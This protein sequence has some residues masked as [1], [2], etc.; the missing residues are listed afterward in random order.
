M[1]KGLDEPDP[2]RNRLDFAGGYNGRIAWDVKIEPAGAD[3][4]ARVFRNGETPSWIYPRHTE[5]ALVVNSDGETEKFLF[6]RGVGNFQ[7]PAV[8]TSYDAGQ[9]SVRN[10][11]DTGIPGLLAFELDNESNARWEVSRGI[12][13]GGTIHVS[14]G[15][16]PFTK[17]WRKR[18]HAEGVQ[19]L[20]DAGL[21]RQEA[22]A[23]LQT[24]W[25][26]YFERAGFRVFWVV[27]RGTTDTILPLSI[28][29]APEKTIRV[30]LG[31]TEILTPVFE[32]VLVENFANPER[33]PW[34]NDRFA[35]AFAARVS[36]LTKTTAQ[37]TP[38]SVP[39]P[40]P[41]ASSRRP[42]P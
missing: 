25:P 40:V 32:N 7:P 17:D 16:T 26:S 19:L 21:F 29:P 5:S 1:T 23:M 36:D 3:A 15:T 9:V 22:D 14:L 27:P 38:P 30:M 37:T 33:N 41:P 42:T 10:A 13:S 2:D 6:Y 39:R 31:R 4:M 8:F 18:V 12:A 11:G 34:R 28:S 24:W 35:P 20:M